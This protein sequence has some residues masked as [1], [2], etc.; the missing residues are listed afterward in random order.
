MSNHP[1]TDSHAIGPDDIRRE[2]YRQLRGYD[3]GRARGD[4]VAVVS[5]SLSVDP[6]AVDEEVDR[7][8]RNGLVYIVGGEVKVP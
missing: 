5:Q 2:V 8:E 1:E 6:D 7:L 3:D 4:L